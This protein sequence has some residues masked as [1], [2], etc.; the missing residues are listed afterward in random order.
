ML[1]LMFLCIVLVGLSLGFCLSRFIVVFGVSLVM[2]DDVFFLLVMICK[3]VDLFELFE[4]R[5]LILVLGKNE[6][7]MFVSICCLVLKN[8]LILYIVKMYLL[9]MGCYDSVVLSFC[10]F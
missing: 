4:L 9:F 5:M 8:L 6:S 3:S 7:E 10:L 1:F 2:F